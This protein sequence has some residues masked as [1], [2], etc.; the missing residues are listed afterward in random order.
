MRMTVDDTIYDCD[1]TKIR[2][3][4]SDDIVTRIDPCMYN[5]CVPLVAK[6]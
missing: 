5:D 2:S 4:S 1:D 6:W 3:S